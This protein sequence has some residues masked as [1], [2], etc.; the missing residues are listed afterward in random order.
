MT[1]CEDLICQEP[2]LVGR[3]YVVALFRS[4]TSNLKVPVRWRYFPALCLSKSGRDCILSV[5]SSLGPHRDRS[6]LLIYS[7]SVY[8]V[9]SVS[10]YY[11]D[12]YNL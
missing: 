9:C 1:C 11:E 8:A 3:A 5:Q 6:Y 10:R 7:T 2:N 12:V 4:R